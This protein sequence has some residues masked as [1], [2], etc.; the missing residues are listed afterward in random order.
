MILLDIV[1]YKVDEPLG[2]EKKL[3][4]E[5]LLQVLFPCLK[6][7]PVCR[8]GDGEIEKTLVE[9]RQVTHPRESRIL[10]GQKEACLCPRFRPG[11]KTA[12]FADRDCEK[13]RR[14]EVIDH[15]G[16]LDLAGGSPQVKRQEY[17]QEH[18]V[19]GEAGVSI[20]EDE[21]Q[22]IKAE[23]AEMEDDV[24]QA[25]KKQPDEQAVEERVEHIVFLER[26]EADQS[27]KHEG[28]PEESEHQKDAHGVDVEYL[29]V[30][31]NR[32][33]ICFSTI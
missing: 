1:K 27:P 4:N 32:Q 14:D 18:P 19:K 13:N 30:Y 8:I 22:E 12:Q 28:G 11:E 9:R 6:Q 31:K 25:A 3:E 10:D 29:Q 24:Y 15:F 21:F 26:A 2:K 20:D 33:H 7:K 23:L 5:P 17:P 16:K